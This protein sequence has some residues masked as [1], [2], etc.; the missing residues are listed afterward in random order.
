MERRP[1]AYRVEDIPSEGREVRVAEAFLE[2]KNA[3]GPFDTRKL[4]MAVQGKIEA[5]LL[6]ERAGT[7]VRVRGPVRFGFTMPCARSNEPVPCRFEE[8]LDVTLQKAAPEAAKAP[9]WTKGG[10]GEEEGVDLSA[11]DLDEWTYEGE[12]LDLAPILYEH[13]A[14]NLPVKVVAERFRDAPEL[15]YSD[16]GQKGSGAFGALRNLKVET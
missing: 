7:A 11:A 16:E 14:L 1:H 12:E 5:D 13:L 10:D 3:Q 6:L 2:G 15:A 4:G 8:P 9:S